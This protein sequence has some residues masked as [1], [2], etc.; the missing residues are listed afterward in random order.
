MLRRIHQKD[1]SARNILI[2]KY[3]RFAWS[4]ATKF[5]DTLFA[6]SFTVE[7]LVS[8][9]FCSVDTAIKKYDAK[10]NKSFYSYWQCIA[11]NAMKTFVRQSIKSNKTDSTVS[12]DDQNEYGGTLHDYVASEDLDKEVSIYNSL[13]CIINDERCNL[14]KL[15]K[16]VITLSLDGY[17]MKEISK[18]LKINKTTAYRNYHS[19]INKIRH[20]IIDKK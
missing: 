19:A 3:H 8:I 2:E 5:F 11:N 1:E 9:A 7:D 4:I 6:V 16:E 18:I 12:L 14:H 15:E 13:V 10:K 17:D 20:S